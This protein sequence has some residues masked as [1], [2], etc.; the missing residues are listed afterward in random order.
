[1]RL[2]RL[3]VLAPALAA[4]ALSAGGCT[5]D[6]SCAGDPLEQ[7]VYVDQIPQAGLS[8]VESDPAT[9]A[10]V[11]LAPNGQLV[12]G[13]ELA[14][15]GVNLGTLAP[16]A[17]RDLGA[18]LGGRPPYATRPVDVLRVHVDTAVPAELAG[19]FD[20]SAWRSSDNVSWT[21]VA[22]DGP[23][24]FHPIL[25]HF[26]I[27][28]AQTQDRYLKVVTRP[29]PASATSDP[30]YGEILVTELELFELVPLEPRGTCP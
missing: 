28:I 7:V 23:V 27:P 30:R 25:L 29:L 22:L 1:V 10:H 13:D 4:G 9:P 19:L 3:L 12:N 15:A 11:E 20:W 14:S 16:I 6:P 17:Y 21:P 5:P 26:E 2:V 24:V 8:I 18:D